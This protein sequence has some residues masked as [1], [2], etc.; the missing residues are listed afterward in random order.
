MYFF[1]FVMNILFFR[2]KTV[3]F[4]IFIRIEKRV[5]TPINKSSYLND[6]VIQ[7]LEKIKKD[8]PYKRGNKIFFYALD[9]SIKS[10]FLF[11]TLTN[12]N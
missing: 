4:F 12:F 7:E 6:F 11:V 3:S 5:L 1:T 9:S 2:C 8:P 10:F